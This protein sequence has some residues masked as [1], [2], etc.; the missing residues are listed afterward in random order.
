MG[1]FDKGYTKDMALK[2]INKIYEMFLESY[3]VK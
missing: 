3:D 2:Y 1:L